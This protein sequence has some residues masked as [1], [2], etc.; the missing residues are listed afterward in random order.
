MARGRPSGQMT[1]LR[2]KALAVIQEQVAQGKPVLVAAVA[3]RIGVDR[4]SARRII[5][6]VHGMA[7]A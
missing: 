7:L 5:A 4:R 3:R 6:D 1:P 2:R